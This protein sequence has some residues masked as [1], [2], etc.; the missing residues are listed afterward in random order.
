MFLQ[1]A[2]SQADVYPAALLH[3]QG[4]MTTTG[5]KLE[6]L[7]VFFCSLSKDTPGCP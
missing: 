5:S 3:I 2:R 4:D 7:A 1:G 6:V